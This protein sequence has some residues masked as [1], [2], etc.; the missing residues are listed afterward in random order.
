MVSGFQ[1]TLAGDSL[2][3][4]EVY[5]CKTFLWQ[6]T[7]QPVPLFDPPARSLPPPGGLEALSVSAQGP[8]PKAETTFQVFL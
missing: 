3:P 8:V 2:A 6:E 1:V 5:S 7:R 4:M